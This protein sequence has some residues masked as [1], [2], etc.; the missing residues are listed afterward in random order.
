MGLL[1]RSDRRLRSGAGAD[2]ARTATGQVPGCQAIGE[3]QPRRRGRFAGIVES[4]KLVP[5]PDTLRLEVTIS[6]G[7]GDL[8][9]VWFGHHPIGGLDLG[10]RVV[11]EGMVG[12][13][14]PGKLEILHPSYQLLGM[15]GDN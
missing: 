14:A 3:C 9:G 12:S 2:R 4:I 1:K 15:P 11:F 10:Q 5:R 7:T 8:S 13:P 6:D